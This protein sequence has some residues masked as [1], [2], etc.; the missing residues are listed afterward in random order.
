M[1]LFVFGKVS[2]IFDNVSLHI[3]KTT[4]TV[5]VNVPSSSS[6]SSSSSSL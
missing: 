4:I 2:D 3:I 6:S 5:M 1:L